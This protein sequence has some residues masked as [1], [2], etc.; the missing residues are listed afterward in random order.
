MSHIYYL[1]LQRDNLF[2]ETH[3]KKVVNSQM[4]IISKKEE[5]KKW[6]TFSQRKVTLTVG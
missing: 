2:K 4:Y 5:N 1:S 6:E 3:K